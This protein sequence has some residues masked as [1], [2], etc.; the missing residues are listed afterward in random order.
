MTR[1]VVDASVAA[2]WFVSEEGTDR[3]H[4]LLLGQNEFIAPPIFPAELASVVTKKVRLAEI[5]A[6]L[7]REALRLAI[8]RV[9]VVQADELV[10]LAMDRAM[11]QQVSVYDALYVE[12]ALR[13]DCQLI[14]ADNRFHRALDSESRRQVLPLA[15]VP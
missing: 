1:Y 15:Q 3:A 4:R 7:A 5:E 2:K 13:E 8:Q 14:T 6:A 10:I 9:A 11:K 12:L